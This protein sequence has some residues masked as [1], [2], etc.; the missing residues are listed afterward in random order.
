MA[1]VLQNAL[2]ALEV[3]NLGG[4]RL[5]GRGLSGL[6]K[7][8]L[9]NTACQQ[10]SLAD[11]MIDQ[12]EDDLVGLNDLKECLSNPQCGLTSVDLLYNRIG[13]KGA[14][15]LVPALAANTKITEFLVDLTLPMPVFGEH[16]DFSMW[17]LNN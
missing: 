13:E 15:V 9:V 8:L 11:N 16:D 6:C 1:E 4:N 7:G 5:G 10:L 17:V 3:L 12:L 2:S 14:L